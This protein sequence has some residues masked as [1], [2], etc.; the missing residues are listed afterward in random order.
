MARRGITCRPRQ[1]TSRP[2]ASLFTCTSKAYFMVIDLI[3]VFVFSFQSRKQFHN[4]ATMTCGH[5][6]FRR[7]EPNF[8]GKICPLRRMKPI[9][10]APVQAG[11]FLDLLWL[12]ELSNFSL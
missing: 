2:T 11:G 8:C 4:S 12:K 1:N 9:D 6:S 7:F 3:V 10:Q 5:A